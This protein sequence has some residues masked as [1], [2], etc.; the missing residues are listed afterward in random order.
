MLWYGVAEFFQEPATSSPASMSHHLRGRRPYEASKHHEF[1]L[2]RRCI[3]KNNIKI[4][5]RNRKGGCELTQDMTGSREHGNK[6][7]Q[8]IKDEEFPE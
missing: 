2:N 6:S 4:G 8:S 5:L 3:W 7:S 1:E